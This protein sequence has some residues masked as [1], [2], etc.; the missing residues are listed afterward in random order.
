MIC[1]FFLHKCILYLRDI[2]VVPISF[3]IRNSRLCSCLDL[4]HFRQMFQY[5]HSLYLCFLLLLLLSLLLSP[6]SSPNQNKVPLE[7]YLFLSFLTI[8]T[9][10]S[11]IT[12]Q[13]VCVQEML[14][15][16]CTLEQ[17]FLLETMVTHAVVV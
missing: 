1:A 15:F 9:K 8:S 6:C 17:S 5:L 3:L 13:V 16:R 2:P 7:K 12:Q 14:R 10:A 11:E 4:A